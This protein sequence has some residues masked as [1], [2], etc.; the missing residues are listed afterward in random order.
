[1]P[2]ISEGLF[3]WKIY[4][5]FPGIRMKKLLGVL[6]AVLMIITLMPTALAEDSHPRP[7]SDISQ[8]TVT[9]E[10]TDQ[11]IRSVPTVTLENMGT[12]QAMDETR[13]RFASGDGTVDNPYSVST[14]EQLNEVRNHAAVC[15]YSL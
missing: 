13:D 15:L 9:P 1:M 12:M 3:C 7:P 10:P 6:L 11:T 2:F 4:Y 8:A 14:P 5:L